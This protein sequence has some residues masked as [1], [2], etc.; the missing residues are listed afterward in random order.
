MRS[1]SSSLVFSIERKDNSSPPRRCPVSSVPWPPPS[2][3]IKE[4][5]VCYS[6]ILGSVGRLL[7]SFELWEGRYQL[8]QVWGCRR[9]WVLRRVVW[10]RLWSSFSCTRWGRSSIASHLGVDQ[11]ACALCH[12]GP[13]VAFLSGDAWKVKE[14]M[15]PETLWSMKRNNV[16]KVRLVE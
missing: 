10:A 14:T 11:D 8:E 15:S 4:G 13:D 3:A 12:H 6:E 7:G 5:K 16:I 2:R 9:R 1:P